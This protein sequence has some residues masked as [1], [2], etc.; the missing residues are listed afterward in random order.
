MALLSEKEYYIRLK[1][2]NRVDFYRSREARERRK[3]ATDSDYIYK[4]YDEII[5]D[6]TSQIY[7]YVEE[8]NINIDD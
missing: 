5:K 6:L 2:N 1:E 3:K 8:N 4:K 7:K